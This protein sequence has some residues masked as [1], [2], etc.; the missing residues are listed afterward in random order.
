MVT[1]APSLVAVAFVNPFTTLVKTA[2]Y[3]S[4]VLQA[5][6]EMF[7]ENPSSTNYNYMIAT[8]LTYQ[9]WG[10]KDTKEFM[11]TEDF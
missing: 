11:I 7:I 9:Y 1:V 10:Q 6:F 3:S 2:A 8:M 4:L 5:A